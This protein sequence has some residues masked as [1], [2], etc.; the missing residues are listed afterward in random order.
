MW[1]PECLVPSGRLRP[2]G[3][4][5]CSAV[6]E[7]WDEYPDV[8]SVWEEDDCLP[9]EQLHPLVYG[10]SRRLLDAGEEDGAVSAAWNA[11]RDLLRARLDSQED[12]MRLIEEIGPARSARLNLT[13]N[14]TLSQRSQHEGVRHLLRGLVSYA[15]NPIAH[16]SAHPFAENRDD[17]IHVLTVM[18]LVAGHL[19]AS[20]T[21]ANVQEAV[22]LLCEPDV[23]LKDQAIAAAISR[24]GR[25]QFGP[26]VHAI[27]TRLGERQDDPRIARALVAG[28]T[29]ALH[30][31]V[32][33]EVFQTAARATSRL[34]MRAPTT[35]SGLV[36]L[37]PGVTHRLDPFA[38][39]K[40]LSMIDTAREGEGGDALMS[41]ARAGEIAASVKKAD[42]E[43]IARQKLTA[44]Q[45]GDAA[46]AVA[47]VE[48][49]AAALNDDRPRG[50]TPLQERFIGVVVERLGTRGEKEIDEALRR[51]FPFSSLSFNLYLIE[52]LRKAEAESDVSHL[53]SEFVREFASLNRWPRRRDSV[54]SR[55]LASCGA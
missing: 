3:R 45:E 23:P 29:L 10:A 6:S 21:R 51:A 46:S 38:Y 1:I 32:D 41:A 44:L 54:V 24:A 5:K 12:G 11:L 20:G 19:E 2:G 22:D 18:S 33:P 40:V 49:L 28:Y 16:D 55:E 36:L 39:A 8:P 17:A 15:R 50:P 27:V 4:G 35:N 9:L 26:L 53:H 13:P 7:P 48:F 25:S 31:S 52:G 43:R 34:L 14:Q 47:A 37:Q 42:G 30:R